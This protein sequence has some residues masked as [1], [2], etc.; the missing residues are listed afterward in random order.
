MQVNMLCRYVLSINI[1]TGNLVN[2]RGKILGLLIVTGKLRLLPQS[3]FI[4]FVFFMGIVSVISFSSQ[5]FY[6]DSEEFV[7]FWSLG[8]QWALFSFSAH[9]LPKSQLSVLIITISFLYQGYFDTARLELA[10]H[11]IHVQTVLPGPVK[12]NISLYAFTENINV[13][14]K[15]DYWQLVFFFLRV[16]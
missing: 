1:N 3:Y 11:N 9:F 5:K 12:S 13:V 15:V 7:N 6:I 14:R 16:R 4:I 2:V 10:E 8:K